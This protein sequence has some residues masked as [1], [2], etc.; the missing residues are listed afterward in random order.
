[1]GKWIAGLVSAVLAAVLIVIGWSHASRFSAPEVGA[2]APEFTLPTLDGDSMSLASYRGQVVLLN[3]WATWCPP[4]IREMPAME[5]VHRQLR[6]RGFTVLAVNVDRVPGVG[7][8]ATANIRTF[9]NDLDLTF[10]ILLPPWSP[11][12]EKR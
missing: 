12:H 9:V 6:E 8:E 2:R 3:F 10:P 1:M 4:C 7:E 5:R 11:S